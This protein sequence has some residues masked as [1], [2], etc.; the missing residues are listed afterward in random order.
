MKQVT[1]VLVVILMAASLL[2]ACTPGSILDGLTKL[3]KGYVSNG[4]AS[5]YATYGNAPVSGGNAL[6]SG[7][8]AIVTAGNVG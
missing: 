5:Y 4:N 6:A 1:I 3:D 7:G 8:N 2:I